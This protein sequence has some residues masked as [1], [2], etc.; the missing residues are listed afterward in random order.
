MVTC[1]DVKTLKHYKQKRAIISEDQIWREQHEK[2]KRL[3]NLKLLTASSKIKPHQTAKDSDK[4]LEPTPEPRGQHQRH[5]NRKI[6]WQYYHTN[7][8]YR[9]DFENS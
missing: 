4:H 9:Q 3:T 6:S 8:C 2:L 1:N 5:G 7:L